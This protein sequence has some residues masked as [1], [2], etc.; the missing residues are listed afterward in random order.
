MNK[1]GIIGCGWLGLP[2]AKSLIA[3]GYHIHGST[4]NQ[5]KIPLLAAG[6]IHPFLISISDQINGEIDSF[7]NVDYLII[8]IPPGRRENQKSH[9]VNRMNLLKSRMENSSI[10]SVIFV[11]STS[12]YLNEEKKMDEN[13]EVLTNNHLVQSEQLFQNSTQWKTTILR[14]SGLINET[15]HPGRFLAGKQNLSNGS[16][17]V[18]LIHLQDCIGIIQTVIKENIGNETFNCTMGAHPTKIEFYTEATKQLQLD[19]PQFNHELDKGGKIISNTK[20][21]EQLPYTFIYNDP[22]LWLRQL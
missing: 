3:K 18:N 5:E 17:P 6:G 14:M 7:L 4:T 8:N 16:A 13:S 12:V 19:I 1:I 11:S 10:H 9:Y 15:R 2:L 20:L 22:L 21:K